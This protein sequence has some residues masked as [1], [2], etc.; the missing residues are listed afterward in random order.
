MHFYCGRITS[1][2]L[3]YVH[4]PLHPLTGIPVS[5]VVLNI[6]AEV[7]ITKKNTGQQ[8]Q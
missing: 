5:S 6:E 2:V 3:I 8:A 4:L 1:L 7:K